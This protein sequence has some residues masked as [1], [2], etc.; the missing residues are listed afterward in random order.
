[1]GGGRLQ[2]LERDSFLQTLAEYAAE[3]RQGDGRLVLVSGE[4]GIGKTALLEEF[5]RRADCTRWLA[6]G[7][8]G[9][10]TPRPLGPVF[11]IGPQAGGEL[12]EL[13]RQDGSRDQLFT[14]FAAALDSPAGLTVAV[15]EDVHW[16]D[17]AT[18]DLLHFLGR[19]LGR[20][21]TL[22]LVSYRDDELAD[23]HPLRVVI[24]DLATQR[25]IRRMRLPPLSAAAV[26][27]LAGPAGLDAAELH[28][29]TGGNP[30]YVAEIVATG[31]PS[32]P[33]TVREIVGARLA[34]LTADGK[35]AVHAAAVIGARVE[36]ALLA[37][38]VPGQ[39][40]LLDECLQSGILIPDG[41]AL[42][43]R[44]EL[45]RMAVDA[46]LSP[47]RKVEL[48]AKLL[49]ALE[50]AGDADP[51]VLAHHAA[52][53]GDEKAV[54]RHAPEAARHSAALGAHREAAAQLERAIRFTGADDEAAL[55]ELH[56]SLAHEYALLDRWP[57][58]E[59]ALE[60]ALALRRLSAD[61]LAVGRVLSRLSRTQWQ[62]CKGRESAETAGQA[63]RILA[64]LPPGPELAQA[65]LAA[66]GGYWS[67]GRRD[68]A[69]AAL[70]QAEDL[71][72]RLGAAALRCSVLTMRGMAQIDAGQDG[73][74]A[75]RQ[76]LDAALAAGLPE[77][78]GGAYVNLQ[79]GCNSLQR[80][81]DAERYYEAGMAFCDKRELRALTRCLHGGQADT[82]LALGRW[83]EAAELCT[84]LLAIPGVS[85]ANQLYPLRDLA[86]IRGRRGD[87]GAGEI[88]DRALALA[89]QMAEPAWLAQARAVQTEMLWLAGRAD[90]AAEAAAAAC[91]VASGRVDPWRWGS[92]AIW[93]WRLRPAS[94]PPPGLP[95]PYA[96]EVAGDFT[97]AA[98]AWQQLGR[99]YEAALV[100][101]QSEDE[102]GLRAAL[103]AFDELGARATAAAIR[104]RMRQ[105]GLTAIPRGPRATTAATP[106]RLT[107]REQQVLAL[108][109]EGLPDREISQRLFISER[110]VHHHVSS[111]LGKI[112][113][114]SRSAVGREA[115][116]LG[117]RL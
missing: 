29:V 95:E 49:A 98:A 112:G 110:T 23:S 8:D 53:A 19:R 106:A 62:V 43:F 94:G 33:V 47:H 74:P 77:E 37:A 87:A 14:A 86:A 72:R 46:S 24:G 66:A 69:L 15:I 107:A 76:S 17:E 16:A 61:Q 117:I 52:G 103:Q 116:R 108:V 30:F 85:P 45:V 51:A 36:P 68:E 56:E 104:R 73:M 80:F 55:A 115:A 64:A 89:V 83:D 41:A 91:A 21:K 2:L 113:V 12:A 71:G 99:P 109:A 93:P 50:A 10:L 97:G 42:Q 90:D 105:L 82:L 35:A 25:S 38:V 20:M 44:H 101:L 100:W 6:G 79:D 114:Q 7:C 84:Q 34:R 54:R 70:A 57:E 27:D 81:A 31:W 4:A 75:L 67:E 78:T 9:L 102:A 26:A 22:L 3:A 63:L 28:R 65:H 48:H 96:L 39:E 1:V 92:L 18:I 60:S 11:D 5:A 58:S 59:R 88:Q 40:Q 13:C 111:I 32:I